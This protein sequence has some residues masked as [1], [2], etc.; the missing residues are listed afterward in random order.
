MGGELSSQR[1]IETSAGRL[2][3][4]NPGKVCRTAMSR[5]ITWRTVDSQ[6]SEMGPG[7]LENLVGDQSTTVLQIRGVVERWREIK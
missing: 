4:E 5:K 6:M 2:A 7:K 1:R 3:L